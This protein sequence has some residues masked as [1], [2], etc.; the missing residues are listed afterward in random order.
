[1]ASWCT[2]LCAPKTGMRTYILHCRIALHCPAQTRTGMRVEGGR[3]SSE[4][5]QTH[6]AS[7]LLGMTTTTYSCS[8]LQEVRSIATSVRLGSS[9]MERALQAILWTPPRHASA[10]HAWSATGARAW[11]PRRRSSLCRRHARVACWTQLRHQ[12]TCAPCR[13]FSDTWA[14]SRCNACVTS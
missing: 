9:Q 8:A 10:W 4:G 11:A 13:L 7:N 12:S 5:A 1:M 6:T 3:T 14:P 2:R